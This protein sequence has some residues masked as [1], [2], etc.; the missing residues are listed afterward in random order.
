VPAVPGG[1][2]VAYVN[3]GYHRY[4]DDRIHREE[5]GT[6]AI[7]ESIRAGLVFQLKRAVGTDLIRER[8]DDFIERA[9]ASWGANPRIQILGHRGGRHLS[10]VSFLIRRGARRLH[11]NFVVAVLNDLF[12][13]QTRG[14]CSCAGPYGHRLLGIDT[15]TSHEF[16]EEILKGNE[17]I[18]PGWIRVNFNYFV[19]E[20][21][22]TFLL[23]AVHLIADHGWA[24]LPLYTFD[25][26][27]GM[28]RH[29][30]ARRE[31]AMRLTD[32]TYPDGRM[33][34]VSKHES[35]SE[36]ALA[37]HLTDA[38]RILED[39]VRAPATA[40]EAPPLSESFERLRWFPLPGEI[41]G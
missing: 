21:V 38:R 39:A 2:T 6:P 31:P 36:S 33:R 35:L 24:L 5:G 11:P 40:A 23:D 15:A 9:L 3:R 8:E 19:S 1:G 27:T 7:S 28:W 30:G 14:G 32:V 37:R 13:I 4:L 18:K 20:T 26:K 22:F 25:P 29:R 12:G 10:I 16:E 17:G 41:E 34:Y